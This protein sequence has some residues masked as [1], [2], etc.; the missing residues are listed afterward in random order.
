[1]AVTTPIA[2]RKDALASVSAG[3]ADAVEDAAIDGQV[4]GDE[5][6]QA[7]A[8]TDAAQSSA[9]AYEQAL[10]SV[11]NAKRTRLPAAKPKPPKVGTDGKPATTRAKSKS[12]KKGTTA[13]AN[14]PKAKTEPKTRKAPEG[15]TVKGN[16]R[17]TAWVTAK[18]EDVPV[19]A[20][21]KAPYKGV[22]KARCTKPAVGDQPRIAMVGILLDDP[23][24]HVRGV[25]VPTVPASE[26]VLA[27]AA[28]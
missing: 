10:A 19:G 15:L 11:P 5:P 16:P 20:R 2:Q 22:V 9:S 8:A 28:K 4:K 6:G 13:K 25:K 21:V 24:E 1:M 18:G 14:A 27:K 23:S 17:T 3:V 26:V 7:K 12:A